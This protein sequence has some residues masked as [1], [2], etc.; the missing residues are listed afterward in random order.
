MQYYNLVASCLNGQGNKVQDLLDIDSE[1][2]LTNYLPEALR[3]WALALH[4]FESTE[5]I[6]KVPFHL[7]EKVKLYA[8]DG[9]VVADLLNILPKIR[10]PELEIF[11]LYYLSV[12]LFDDIVEDPAKFHSKFNY[13][14]KLSLDLQHRATGM[15]FILHILAAISK[16]LHENPEIYS[17]TAALRIE[18]E[19][20]ESLSRQAIFFTREKELSSLPTEVLTIKQRQVS[21]EATSFLAVALQLEKRYGE[22][23]AKYLKKSLFYLGSLTQFTDDIRD[24]DKDKISGNMN[25]LSSMESYYGLEARR[26]FVGWYLKEEDL[27]L[28]EIKKSKLDLDVTL[29]KAI[30]WHPFFLKPL[31]PN[32]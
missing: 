32:I 30:P 21:G 23:V 22:K 7:I 31:S 18:K 15:S 10:K 8:L 17:A 4:K 24:Y 16:V 25:L 14:K 5:R 20:V 28:E 13:N 1:A 19:F 27:M 29:L 12:H 9:V 26:K 6:S 2:K 3:I 11:S